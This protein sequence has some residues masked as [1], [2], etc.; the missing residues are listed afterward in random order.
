MIIPLNIEREYKEFINPGKIELLMIIPPNINYDVFVN[1][2][3]NISTINK[4]GRLYGSLITDIP[5]GPISLS[6]YLKKFIEIE[7]TCLDFNTE[8]NKITDFNFK[9][10]YEYFDA[11]ISERYAD[12]KFDYVG[13]SALFTTT[14]PSIIDLAKI[15]KKYFK[16]S[17]LMVGGNFPTATYEN[18][19]TDSDHI[20]V[21]CYGEGEKPLLNLL[22]AKNRE[23]YI[24]MSKSWIN[25]RKLKIKEFKPEHDFIWELDEIPP[26]DYD[27]LDLEAYKINPTSSRYAVSEKNADFDRDVAKESVE[28]MLVAT[29]KEIFHSMPIM[30][31]RG[32]PFKCTFCASHAAHGRDMRYYSHERVMSDVQ[33]MIDKFKIDGVVIQD[34]HF[35]AGK[36]RPYKIVKEIGQLGLGMFFQNALALYAL[37]YEFLKLLKESGVDELVLPV[38]SGSARVLK[39]LMKKPLRLEIIP[40]VLKDCRDAGI[41]TDCNI[42]LGMP[43]ETIQDIA[44]S[45]KF[46]KTIYADWFRVFVATPIPGSD[47]FKHCEAEKLFDASPMLADYKHPIVTTEHLS[48][49]D[50]QKMTYLMNIELNFVYNSNMRLGKYEIAIESFK[51]VLKVKPDHAI[52]HLYISICYEKLGNLEL[53]EYHQ[54]KSVE[55]RNKFWDEIIEEL[56]IDFSTKIII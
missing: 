25:K 13:I 22:M 44:D 55:F 33:L 41:F 45:R 32:C 20:D 46:L 48:S 2:P 7:I 28:E 52:A 19:L 31:S 36:Y 38:E 43:G 39:E 56:N 24:G 40:R 14:Y 50:V 47:M 30:T 21:V 12:K 5:L 34:D 15:S 27:I 29:K 42:I 23:E 37:D 9:S 1:P 54:E 11:V 35:M 4:N 10:F 16:D 3:E 49:Q 26:L 17:F 18:L 6:A 53:F 8:L 51:N